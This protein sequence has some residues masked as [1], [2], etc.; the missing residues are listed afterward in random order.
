MALLGS[1]GQVMTDSPARQ[2][3]LDKITV[4]NAEAM[5]L[6]DLAEHDSMKLLIA[7]AMQNLGDAAV[8]LDLRDTSEAARLSIADREITSA[9][10]K[11][12]IVAAGPN[13]PL[14]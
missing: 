3:R 13:D 10:H 8:W 9:A 5:R 14:I 6:L 2:E 12:R 4:L 7:G 11:L 1:K